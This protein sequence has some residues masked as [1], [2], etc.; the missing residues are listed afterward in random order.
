MWLA[1]S[2]CRVSQWQWCVKHIYTQQTVEKQRKGINWFVVSSNCSTHILLSSRSTDRPT[3]F[4]SSRL[5]KYGVWHIIKSKLWPVLLSRKGT[6]P[7]IIFIHEYKKTRSAFACHLFWRLLFMYFFKLSK[8]YFF[9]R[10]MWVFVHCY[11]PSPVVSFMILDHETPQDMEYGGP[12]LPK[13]K[14]NE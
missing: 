2:F 5:K 9:S 10:K 13:L 8:L 1:T 3:L 12:N 11:L 4:H 6:V 14:I 7:H